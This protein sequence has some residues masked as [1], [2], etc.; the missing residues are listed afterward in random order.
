MS[1]IKTED[2]QKWINSFLAIVSG[3]CGFVVIRFFHQMSE[4]F[5]LEAKIPQ[6]QIVVQVVGILVG[7][8]VFISIIKNKSASEHLSGVYSELVKVVW[9]NKDDVL[10]T[11]IGLIFALSI[12]S[13]I[14]V[15]VDFGVRKL[16]NIIL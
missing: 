2:S 7:L 13:G 3:I 15:L 8:I 9:P 12:I 4:W 16:L 14:F 1:L 6:F 11:T 10:K 5:D